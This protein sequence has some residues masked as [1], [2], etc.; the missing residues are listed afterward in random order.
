MALPATHAMAAGMSMAD[1]PT[2]SLAAASVHVPLRAGDC[3]GG[4]GDHG[5]MPSC[6]CAATFSTALTAV[7]ALLLLPVMPDSAADGT[8]KAAA[9]DLAH[10]PPLR[11][12][13]A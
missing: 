4:D 13:A 1:T 3:C 11:P 12:P 7:D 5:D 8:R 6:H 2:N 9:P 10:P